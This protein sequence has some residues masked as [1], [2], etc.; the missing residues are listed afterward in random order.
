[1]SSNFRYQG[2]LRETTLPEMLATF[3]HFQV[4][5]V[6]EAMSRGVVKRIQIDRGAVLHASST[7]LEDSLGSYLLRAGQLT[8][9][10]HDLSMQLRGKSERRLGA[11]L[12]EMGFLSPAEVYA[13]IRS[14]IEEIV[15]S[16]FAWNEGQVSFS[17]GSVGERTQVTL[18]L[19]M[20]QVIL[21]GIKRAG[22]AKSLLARVGS[23]ETVFSPCYQ[24]EDLIDCGLDGD[25]YA[26]LRLVDGHR[27]LYEVCTGGPLTAPES[28]KLMYAFQVLQLIRRTGEPT[29]RP[30]PSQGG[31]VVIRLKTPGDTESPDA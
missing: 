6:I 18:R 9:A 21:A 23:R 7:D 31:K 2:D 17:I 15:W 25:D 24:H 3:H 5:G 22:N 30:A 20:R 12:V 16:L 13:A 8:Q 1:M 10:Q 4:P 14:H 26:L 27:T 11:L 29:N 28:A 19:P